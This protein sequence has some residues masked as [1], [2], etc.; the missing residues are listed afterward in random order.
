MIFYLKNLKA[1]TYKLNKGMTYVELIVVLSI[2]SIMT[3]IVLFNY[4]A[5]Q[6]KV[7]IKVL[8]NDIASKIVEAQ[9]AAL[10][11]ALPLRDYTIVPNW[12]PSYGLYFDSS[13]SNNKNFIYFAD[14]DQ[15]GDYTDSGSCNSTTDE[16]L[17]NIVITK[18]NSISKIDTYLGPNNTEITNLTVI[19][20][21]PNSGAM[22]YSDG[23]LLSNFDY[24]QITITSSSGIN[25]YIRIYPSGRIQIN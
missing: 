3:S 19:F 9:K 5:F 13:T 21:R 22:L 15:L 17:D 1:K 4:G 11:G 23:T 14:L 2:F 16:C 10:S 7:D 20:K 18:N 25:A 8:A 24:V 12:K 6:Q